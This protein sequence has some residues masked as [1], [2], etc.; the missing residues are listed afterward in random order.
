MTLTGPTGNDEVPLHGP[1]VVGFTDAL[2]N[3]T[4]D[5]LVITPVGTTTP[6]P[7]TRVCKN[8]A[9]SV[10]ACLAGPV[11]SVTITPVGD[12][13]PTLYQATLDPVGAAP[14]LL[15]GLPVA[16]ATAG[17]VHLKSADPIDIT[18][19][20]PDGPG[21]P[22]DPDDPLIVVFPVNVTNITITNINIVLDGTDDPLPGTLVCRDDA[23]AIVDCIAGP[24]HTVE[25]MP[26]GPLVPG[27]DYL[28]IINQDGVPPILDGG[29]PVPPPDPPVEITVTGTIDEL[30][31]AI[32]YR[33]GRVP[34]T[35][36]F[37]RWYTA[38][39]GRGA[40]AS[41]PFTGHRIQWVTVEGPG[42]GRATVRIDGAIV[43]QANL[44]A[45]RTHYGAI[46]N[47]GGL[48]EADHVLT[49]TAL[50][51]PG[52]KS[53]KGKAVAI[54][55]FKVWSGGGGV[56]LDQ[57]PTPV[58][59]WSPKTDSHAQ[60]GTFVASTRRRAS[61][62]VAFV[63][64]AIEWHTLIGP[65]QGQAT[66]LVDGIRKAV[67]HN[68]GGSSL[69]A[70]TRTFDGFTDGLHLLRIVVQRPTHG[71]GRSIAIDGFVVPG[72]P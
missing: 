23:D 54:D 21:P 66:V 28:V 46:R 10:V 59:T 14:A 30:S 31:S 58:Y 37:G 6:V 11:R 62:L 43:D 9:E 47:Y 17:P 67:V 19:E 52:R 4:A 3:V 26:D 69:V 34:K 41:F 45:R 42:F 53:S 50:G 16:S 36:S 15:G 2:T 1:F 13:S 49:V 18:I 20:G 40:T 24:V 33:W 64:T 8:A 65:G 48:T 35:L 5:N 25:F 27:G 70:K 32:R 56:V 68:S 39:S 55:A 51:Q 22:P 60:E 44:W 7:G 61:T 29:L 72:A 57:S 12:L 38:E 71:K 63:G